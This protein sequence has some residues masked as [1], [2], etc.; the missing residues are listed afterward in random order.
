MQKKPFNI[1]AKDLEKD[2]MEKTLK[3][4]AG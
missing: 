2:P 3:L 4:S 1:R